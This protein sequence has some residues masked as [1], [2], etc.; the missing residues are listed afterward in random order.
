[1]SSNTDTKLDPKDETSLSSEPK[2]AKTQTELATNPVYGDGANEESAKETPAASGPTVT[3]QATNVA[4]DTTSA[5]TAA[6]AGVSDNVFSMFGGGAKK[7]KKK[8][9]DRGDNSGSAKAQKAAAEANPEDEAPPSEDVHFEPVIRL[10]KKVEVKTHEELEGQTYK[11]RAKKLFRFDSESNQWKE[12][13]TGEVRLLKHKEN[14]KTRLVMRT[15]Q[16]LKVRANHYV[17]PEMKLVANVGSN[18]SWVWNTAA[19]VSEGLPEAMTFAIRFD[20]PDLAN[21]FKDAFIKA[22]Q[23]NASLFP[24]A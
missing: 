24:K 13:G 3:E 10:T 18:R 21:E 23:E 6:A 20:T 11:G 7:E 19:D 5:V 1:M 12:R 4:S 17:V 8:D 15:D 16:V 22:Q 2:L 14:G 9:E